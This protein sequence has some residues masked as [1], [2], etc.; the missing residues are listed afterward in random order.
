MDHPW[1]YD[2]GTIGKN[3]YGHHPLYLNKEKS[4]KF[5]LVFFRNSNAMDVTIDHKEKFYDK[6]IT[7]KTVG[8][9]IDF[10]FFLGTTPDTVIDK[11]HHYFGGWN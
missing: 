9:I 8:G 3:T 1:V 5:N 2:D 7:Y 11:Y 10:R 4:N 6:T